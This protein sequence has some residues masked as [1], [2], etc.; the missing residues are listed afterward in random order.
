MDERRNKII[1]LAR[2]MLRSDY[3][4]C[5][6]A[7]LVANR[8]PMTIPA[9]CVTALLSAFGSSIVTSAIAYQ[10]RPIS[11]YEAVEIEALLYYVARTN[12]ISD[13]TLRDEVRTQLGLSD[14]KTM[15]V[16]EFYLIRD[17]LR[18]RAT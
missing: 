18:R 9:L 7:T 16:R 17:Y 8:Q 12:G 1:H 10:Q 4:N 13:A 2:T 15:S 5:A 3:A 6:N 14:F 11:H